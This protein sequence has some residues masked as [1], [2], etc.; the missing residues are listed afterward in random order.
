MSEALVG[1]IMGSRSDWE[2]MR[3]AAE[4][5]DSLGVNITALVASLDEGRTL[6][7]RGTRLFNS[8]HF[9]AAMLLGQN[10]TSALNF[11]WTGP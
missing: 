4:T 7:L 1:I 8:A 3:H 2:T 10:R 11:S 6:G 5:L 9:R